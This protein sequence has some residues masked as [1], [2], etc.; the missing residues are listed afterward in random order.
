MATRKNSKTLHQQLR[1][2]L[3]KLFVNMDD[4][5][6]LPTE[7]QLAEKFK[8]SRLT[9]HKALNELHHE[10]YVVR[11]AGKGSFVSHG[12]HQVI[13]EGPWAQEGQVI[14]AYPDWFSFDIWSKRRRARQLAHSNRMAVMDYMITQET[15]YTKLRDVVEETGDVKGVIVIPPAGTI[16]PES[17]KLFEDLNVPVV[18]LGP[19]LSVRPKSRKVF[20]VHQDFSLVGEI[21]VR[22]LL[23]RGHRRIAYIASEPLDES[24]GLEVSGM[25]Q[26]LRDQGLPIKT[27]WVSDRHA[28]P[29]ELA[30]D[31]AAQITRDFLEK[32]DVCAMIFDSIPDAMGGIRAVWESDPS[33]LAKLDIL[34]TATWCGLEKTMVPSPILVY[35]DVSQT[36]DDAFDLILGKKSPANR[37]VLVQSISV[38]LP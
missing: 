9:V 23:D 37:K 16:P 35:C 7:V 15:L 34:V 11:K 28:Q 32:N 29:W 22:T 6:Q 36:V 33:A 19:N 10:G 5:E 18:I 38:E 21:A 17:I 27:L 8:V 1:E 20:Q 4:G 2:Y 30:S 3:L 14:M 26:A 12:D 31:M 24:T 25:K 13:T